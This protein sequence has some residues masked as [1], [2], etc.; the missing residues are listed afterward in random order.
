LELG[1]L[2]I[3]SVMEPAGWL[4]YSSVPAGI[5]DEC[6]SVFDGLVG[7]FLSRRFDIKW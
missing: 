3:C 6:F 4:S 5:L 7:D 2:A 1:S